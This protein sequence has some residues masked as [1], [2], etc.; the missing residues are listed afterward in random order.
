MSANLKYLSDR[1]LS[2]LRASIKENA[3]RYRGEG[4]SARADDPAWDIR[5]GVEYDDQLLATLDLN[6]PRAIAA[7]DLENSK[8]VG[9]ALQKLTPSMANEERVWVRLAHVEA[10]PYCQARW[11]GA[12]TDEKLVEVVSDHFFAPTQTGIRDDHALSRLWWN[13]QIATTCMPEDPDEALRLIL[14]TADIRSNFVERIWLTS[15][16]SI[17]SSVL[18]AMA[19]NIWISDA[20]INFRHFM[21][22][23]NKLGGG[24]VFEALDGAETE[25]FVDECVEYARRA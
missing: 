3:Q 10:F 18:R 7:I 19:A 20:E 21:K 13:Y 5:L 17:A 14:K 25:K 23:L 8:I 4:F 16:R 15:R 6:A 9:R 22:V 12:A 2:Q 1:A 11:I 24:I